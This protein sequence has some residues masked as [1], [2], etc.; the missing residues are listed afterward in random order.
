MA[1]F[2]GLAEGIIPNEVK[3]KGEPYFDGLKFYKVMKSSLAIGG[4]PK[5]DGTG[6]PGYVFRDEFHPAL[7]HD[8]AGVI[9]M[10][11]HGP[12]TN[13]SQFVIL[14][15]AMPEMDNINPVFGRVID[16]MDTLNA[17]QQGETIVHIEIIRLGRKAKAFDPIKIF[18]E[19]G[20]GQMLKK[21]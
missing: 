19:N 18:E 9:S 7:K 14:M 15:K 2:I 4:C 21:Q 11:S 6:H 13:G 16:G 3:K 10:I 1:N 12:N 17:V 8:K 5:G 20:F